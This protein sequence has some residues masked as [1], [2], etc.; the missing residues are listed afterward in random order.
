MKKNLSRINVLSCAFVLSAFTCSC[1]SDL[2]PMEKETVSP[3]AISDLKILS[4]KEALAFEEMQGAL[5]SPSTRAGAL[6]STNSEA[7]DDAKDQIDIAL[8]DFVKKH[9][10]KD[11]LSPQEKAL[12]HL[13]KDS[14][15][16]IKSDPEKVLNLIK[17]CRTDKFYKA[18]KAFISRGKINMELNDII[19]DNE[20]KIKEKVSLICMLQAGQ[21]MFSLNTRA[22]M[23][24]RAT[25]SEGGNGYHKTPQQLCAD[26]RKSAEASCYARYLFDMGLAIA[27]G[28]CS[29]PFV[30]VTTICAAGLASTDYELCLSSAAKD[31]NNCISMIRR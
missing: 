16:I 17:S 15:D 24:T 1:S 8:N 4:E 22:Q 7:I 31:Y 19:Y 26:Q 10:I 18:C 12:S 5:L 3:S 9:N 28:L 13:S 20:L 14:I 11:D 27:G 25:T 6:T 30:E 2:T 23:M 21:S 29:G